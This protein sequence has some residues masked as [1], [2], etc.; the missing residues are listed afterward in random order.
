MLCMLVLSVPMSG[1]I[2]S[3]SR[4][5]LC[6]FGAE[7]HRVPGG[8]TWSNFVH[9]CP[10]SCWLH[11]LW[12]IYVCC[13]CARGESSLLRRSGYKTPRLAWHERC[14]R[15]KG[16][17]W[18]KRKGTM[19]K[20]TQNDGKNDGETRF[21]LTWR[22]HL[23]QAS[24]RR[25]HQPLRQPCAC[26]LLRPDI[27]NQTKAT[28]RCHRKQFRKHKLNKLN[29]RR[30]KHRHRHYRHCKHSST[31]CKCSRCSRCRCRHLMDKHKHKHKR[32]TC[33]FK[34]SQRNKR[35]HNKHKQL[36]DWPK[37]KKM[38]TNFRFSLD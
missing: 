38:N 16:K 15:G 27:I 29:K 36:F 11:D 1:W 12:M 28:S 5:K 23:L 17:R 25:M 26:H 10:V 19:G 31:T 4:S 7:V 3:R 35:K 37:H 24:H 30:H 32:N 6:T 20:P 8:K 21:L 13:D 14:P 33:I 2:S 9:L 34:E 22:L 18:K